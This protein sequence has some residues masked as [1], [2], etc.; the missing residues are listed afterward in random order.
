MRSTFKIS[1]KIPLEIPLHQDSHS[2]LAH[3]LDVRLSFL[4]SKYSALTDSLYGTIQQEINVTHLKCLPNLMAFMSPV[5]SYLRCRS[6]QLRHASSWT[7]HSSSLF[8]QQSASPQ[9][10]PLTVS[11]CLTPRT[12][13]SSPSFQDPSSQCSSSDT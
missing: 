13:H 10:Q 7:R 4:L 1:S 5:T 9:Q 8:T 11:W 3:D 2:R 6:V 12:I